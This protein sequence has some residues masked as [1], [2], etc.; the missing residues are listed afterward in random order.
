MSNEFCCKP[1]KLFT[2]N[3]D[4]DYIYPR[5]SIKIFQAIPFASSNAFSNFDLNKKQEDQTIPL[6]ETIT[7]AHLTDP[8]NNKK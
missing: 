4:N 2:T 3:N 8:E 7:L 5:S 6:N 1:K